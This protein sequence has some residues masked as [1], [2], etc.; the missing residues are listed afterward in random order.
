MFLQGGKGQSRRQQDHDHFPNPPH[1]LIW[2]MEWVYSSPSW[3][4]PEVFHEITHSPLECQ[5]HARVRCIFLRRLL[6]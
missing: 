3:S 5:G 1:K 4:W 2:W 6:A